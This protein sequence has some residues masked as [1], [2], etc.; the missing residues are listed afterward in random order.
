MK[1]E[2]CGSVYT[3]NPLVITK[4]ETKNN[5]IIAQ[6]SSINLVK[7]NEGKISIF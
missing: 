3:Y 7:L 1:V 6:N 2:V 4:L 5:N